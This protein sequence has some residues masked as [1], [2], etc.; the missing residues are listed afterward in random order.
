VVSIYGI[1]DTPEDWKG[2]LRFGLFNLVSGL[3]RDERRAVTLPANASILLARFDRAEWESQGTTR[4]GAFALLTQNGQTV[5]QHRL[6]VE[7]FKDL[8]FIEPTIKH[9][10]ENGRLTLTSDGFAWGVC[11]DLDGELPLADNCFDLIPGIPYTLPWS[12]D[13]GEP[14]ILRLGNRDAVCPDT[15]AGG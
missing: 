4:S 1:N 9:Q 5:A 6:F 7:R 13:L 3:P 14:Q 12:D 8:R 11:L 15:G 2:D 10:R